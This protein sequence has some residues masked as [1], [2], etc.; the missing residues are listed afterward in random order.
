[1]LVIFASRILDQFF[2]AL[3]AR[4]AG[5]CWRS[6]LGSPLAKSAL[7]KRVMT[8]SL[9]IGDSHH[10]RFLRPRP[11]PSSGR[12]RRRLFISSTWPT[13]GAVAETVP[14]PYSARALRSVPA[15]FAWAAG[16]AWTPSR[17]AI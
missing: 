4:P 8:I 9:A 2:N 16:D 5:D 6:A 13:S 15:E 3:I 12:S 10:G 11:W 14:A 1:M 17:T 7:C